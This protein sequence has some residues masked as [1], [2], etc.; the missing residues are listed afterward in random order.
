MPLAA[1]RTPRPVGVARMRIV[2]GRE[3]RRRRAEELPGPGD[4][5]APVA[6]GE[7]PEVPDAHEAAREH[8]QEKAPEEFVNAE[9]HDL[10][11]ASVG[12]VFPAEL[13]HAVEE[14]D[15]ARIRDGDAMRVASE[16]LEDLCRS[17]KRLLR[18]H[19]P[20]RGPEGREER[21]EP[22]RIGQRRRASS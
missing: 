9:G 14:A 15:E 8:V 1:E 3:R 17:A 20:R 5:G 21:G 2:R 7:Q 22:A 10:R 12:V 19:D 16:V 4:R 18:V 13:D 6:I 11:A